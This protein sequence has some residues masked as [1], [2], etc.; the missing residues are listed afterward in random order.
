MWLDILI[1]VVTL[2]VGLGLGFAGGVYYLKNQMTKMQT[3]PAMLQ[4]MA[5]QMGYNVNQKQ[6]N[7]MKHMMKKMK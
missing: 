4:K 3:D 1:P 6:I 5:K 2:I 7:Q